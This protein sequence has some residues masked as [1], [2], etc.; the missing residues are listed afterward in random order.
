MGQGRWVGG[1]G[2]FRASV[3]FIIIY[4]QR[5]ASTLGITGQC[6]WTKDATRLSCMFLLLWDNKRSCEMWAVCL[7]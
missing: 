6:R 3:A 5:D 1:R 7:V 4:E 2:E